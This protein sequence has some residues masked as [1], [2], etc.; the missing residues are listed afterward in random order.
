MLN[1]VEPVRLSDVHFQLIRGYIATQAVLVLHNLTVA[2]D[3]EIFK[4]ILGPNFFVQS[5]CPRLV[6]IVVTYHFESLINLFNCKS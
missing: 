3:A 2:V 1:M 4:F 5:L 6:L